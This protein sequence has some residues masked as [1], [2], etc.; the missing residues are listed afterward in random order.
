MILRLVERR[1]PADTGVYDWVT[2]TGPAGLLTSL[3]A[4]LGRTD[5]EVELVLV[6]DRTMVGLNEGF[7]QIPEVTDVLSFSYLQASGSGAPDLAAGQDH[8][9]AN[10]WLDTIT[11]DPE[12]GIAPSVGEVVLAPGFVADRCERR[13]WSLEHEFPLLVVHGLLHI[14]GWEHT[15]SEQ[16]EAMQAVEEKILA[17]VGLPH[18]LRERS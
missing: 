6:D 3:A 4:P 1:P 8:A 15:S 10:L 14:L 17:A 9:F 16:T 11:S 5:W 18:P 13:R 2:G 12:N 7:R